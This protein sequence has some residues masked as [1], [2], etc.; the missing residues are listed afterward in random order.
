MTAIYLDTAL[1]AMPNYAIDDHTGQEIISRIIHFSELVGPDMPVNL[2]ISSETEALLWGNNLGPD[3]EQIEAFLDVMN[4]KH[5]YSANDLLQRYNILLQQCIRAKDVNVME[6]QQFS[7]FQSIPDL[8]SA[9]PSMLMKETQRIFVTASALTSLSEDIRVGSAFFS[10]TASAYTISATLGDARG[11]NP[12]ALGTLPIVTQSEVHTITHLRDLVSDTI[13]D[14]IWRN[15]KTAG[16]LHFAITLG[17]LALLQDAGE[18]ANWTALKRFSIGSGFLESLHAVEC[19]GE[20]RFANATRELCSQIVAGKCNR[21]I[22]PFSLTGQYERPFD[23]AR[24]WRTHLTNSGLALRLMF[25]EGPRGLEYANV[26][27]K[28][29]ET[30]EYGDKTPAAF[31]DLSEHF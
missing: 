22:N 10:S 16:D 19:S 3:Y 18:A 17:A 25:W 29:G 4:L 24:A 26:D 20:G 5:I 7:D 23:K 9:T 30:I 14:R 6:A 12:T 27:V 1:L 31:I 13:A 21:Q 2:I 8:P 28:N 15:A 11:S